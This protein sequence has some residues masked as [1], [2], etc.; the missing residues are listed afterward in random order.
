M[1]TILL[2]VLAGIFNSIMDA[3]RYRWDKSYFNNIKNRELFIFCNPSLSQKNKY[4]NRDPKQGPKFFGSTTFLVWT[5]D[6]WHLVKAGMI[7]SLCIGTVLYTRIINPW[8]DALILLCSFTITFEIF[9]SK[10]WIKK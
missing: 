9:F 4:K 1:I 3:I 7:L 6:L 10:I 2:F 5:T 8:A